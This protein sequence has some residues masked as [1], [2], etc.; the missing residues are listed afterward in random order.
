MKMY[1]PKFL[2]LVIEYKKYKE[3]FCIENGYQGEVMISKTGNAYS[4]PEISVIPPIETQSCHIDLYYNGNVF[5]DTFYLFK[6]RPPTSRFKNWMI[7]GQALIPSYNMDHYH[8]SLT[9]PNREN[10]SDSKSKGKNKK[11]KN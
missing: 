9:V 6:D 1:K 3:S 10:N 5:V 11:C 8:I 4:L 7:E 2:Y